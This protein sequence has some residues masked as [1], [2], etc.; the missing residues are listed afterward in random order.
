MGCFSYICQGCCTP[1]NSNSYMGEACEL[2]LLENGKVLEHLTGN[3]NSYG[4]IFGADWSMDWGKICDLN[5]NNRS[6]DGI[7]AFHQ[8]CWKGDLPT[9]QSLSDPDQG[10]GRVRK[11]YLRSRV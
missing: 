5:F 11:K 6:S 2:F 8:R 9:R 1:I 4:A 10:W 7:A 3:Y